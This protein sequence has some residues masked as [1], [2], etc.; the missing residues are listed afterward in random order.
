MHLIIPATTS[1]YFFASL[2]F[3]ILIKVSY[4]VV[5]L[6]CPILDHQVLYI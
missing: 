4:K 2:D 6:E 1:G 3:R 5:D